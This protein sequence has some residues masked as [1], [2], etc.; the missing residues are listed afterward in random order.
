MK[1]QDTLKEHLSRRI[2]MN[3]RYSLRAFACALGLEPSK[4]SE[5][6]SGKKGLS[7]DRADVVCERLRLKGLDR[8]LFIL[9]VLS[10]HSR[11]K[12]QR[13]ES[14][15]KL[16][17][18][19]LSKNTAKERTMQKNAWYFGAV[20]AT[21]ECGLDTDKLG[22]VLRLTHLQVENANRYCERIQKVHPERQNISY[23]PVSLM[24]KLNEDFS[25]KAVTDLEAEFV[26]LTAEQ[27][28]TLSGI[29]CRKVAEFSKS[30]QESNRQE[31]KIN[32]YMLLSGF[33]KLCSKEDIC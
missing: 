12:K 33:S 21:R 10:Q 31:N 22:S 6:L 17:E 24:K 5:V 13:D 4:L 23:E 30:N 32:L 27:V 28:T 26:F 1:Y 16:K 14:A 19:V 8:D 15:K 18:L 25:L 3:P 20:H 11:I 9:S 29:V 2:S 7:A